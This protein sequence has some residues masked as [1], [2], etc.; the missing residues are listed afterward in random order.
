MTA[1]GSGDDSR[2]DATPS[3]ETRSF[4]ADNGTI[5]FPVDPQRIVAVSGG[6]TATLIDWGLKPVGITEI[7]RYLPWAS[8]EEARVYES[9]TVVSD[10]NEVDYETVASLNPDLII[11]AVPAAGFFDEIDAG[12][13]ESIAPTILYAIETD[14]W[15]EKTP[16]LAEALGVLDIFAEQKTSYD[17]LVDDVQATYGESLDSMTFAAVN[18]WS[19]EDT[20]TFF[21]EYQNSTCTYYLSDAGLNIPGEPKVVGQGPWDEMSIERLSDL[22][23]VDAV[24]YPLDAKGETQE[25]FKSILDSNIWKSFSLVQ[26]GMVLPVGCPFGNTT[27]ANGVKNLESLKAALGKLLNAE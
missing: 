4:E 9:A 6:A 7:P 1:C 8:D 13:L 11:S 20:G 16:K 21:R 27:Y 14:E 23:D 19:P 24:I 25:T 26:D 22:S 12:R 3:G 5:E 17:A 2:D 10:G 15:R 18:K